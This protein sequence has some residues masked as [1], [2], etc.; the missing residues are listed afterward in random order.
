M[1]TQAQDTHPQDPI[2]RFALHIEGMRRMPVPRGLARLV[3]M[4]LVE[5]FAF[6]LCWAA[7]IV[8]QR[9]NGTL[10]TVA[11]VAAREPR[12]RPEE[13]RPR[14]RCSTVVA[15]AGM[16][17]RLRGNDGVAMNT[18]VAETPRARARTLNAS[19][20]PAPARAQRLDDGVWS[21]WRGSGSVWTAETGCLR[22]D[23]KKWALAGADTCVPFV[24]Y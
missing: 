11:P 2:D 8:E 4:L 18:P 10:P 12:A 1:T 7:D 13:P 22:F 20:G 6:L 23:S 19:S 14:E 9:R 15:A 24:T 5:F 3:H 21:Q 17:S 16:D